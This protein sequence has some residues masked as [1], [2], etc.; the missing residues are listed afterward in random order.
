MDPVLDERSLVKTDEIDP[1]RRVQTLAQALKTLHQL[2]AAKVLRTLRNAPH[3]DIGGGR[4]IVSWCR[5]KGVDRDAGLYVAK[6]LGKQP[7]IDGQDGLLFLAQKEFAFEA[8]HD[9]VAVMGLAVVALTGGVGVA[10]EGVRSGGQWPLDV[11]FLDEA[12]LR[13]ST[14][15]VP[16]IVTSDDAESLRPM[17]VERI[18]VGVRN[19]VD[20]VARAG[21]LFPRLRFG[22]DAID[23][24]QPLAGADALFKQL[25]WHLR[26]LNDT[27]AAW[28]QGP[29]EPEGI[30]WS[31]ESLSTLNHGRFGP[32]RDFRMPEGF[33]PERWKLHTK[34]T[35][36]SGA[37]LYFRFEAQDNDP[38]VLLGYFGPHL[39]TVNF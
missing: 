9:D 2:G 5:D 35:G 11:A 16:C 27:A 20:L 15:K 4:G 1:P 38:V 32:L 19:G 39:R 34:L 36:G 10:L 21:D 12:G 37:R 18:L 25:F 8:K 3:V 29:F 33:A 17:L 23:G 7:F 24:I 14:T 13:V 30:P 31:T 22:P 26:S 28:S 6:L